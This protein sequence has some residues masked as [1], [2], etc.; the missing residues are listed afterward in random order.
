MQAHVH[1]PIQRAM[2]EIWNAGHT[3]R[4]HVDAS[5]ADVVVPD[6]VRATW[7]ARLILDLEANMPLNLEYDAEQM[8]LDLAFRGLVA[9]CHLPWRSI[10]VVLDRTT[11]QG[12]VIEAHLPDELKSPPAA[13]RRS[14]RPAAEE[15]TASIR[16]DRVDAL[17]QP[18]LV[19]PVR[20]EAE[21]GAE[22]TSGPT[23]DEAKKRRARF[24]V[25]DGGQR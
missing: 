21:P 24:K 14:S 1:H 15:A 12:F 18:M 7:G 25:I 11:G 23:D 13:E 6:S 4:I 9:R 19:A 2:D 17:S 16:A 10:Y 5:R 20:D 8:H 3:P 22:P